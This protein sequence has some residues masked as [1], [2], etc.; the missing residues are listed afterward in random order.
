[1]KILKETIYLPDYMGVI[2]ADFEYDL[3]NK[4]YRVDSGQWK[5]MTK[6][7]YNKV[8]AKVEEEKE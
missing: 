1:M 8:I 3:E 6:Y 4:K 2:K 7:I 5:P